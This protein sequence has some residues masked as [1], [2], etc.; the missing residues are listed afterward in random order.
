MSDVRPPAAR[1]LASRKNLAGMA[2]ALVGCGFAFADV[3][4]WPVVAVALYGVG[5]LL[6]PA[7]RPAR[8]QRLTEVLRAELDELVDRSS[9]RRAAALPGGTPAAVERIADVLR[10]VLDRLDDVADRAVDRN[11]APERLA[12]VAAIV[13]SDLPECLEGYLGRGRASSPGRAAAQLVRQLD[14]IAAAV[15]RLAADVPDQH[16]LRAEELTR[17]LLRR[18]G[19]PGPTGG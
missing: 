16:A 8:E 17:D 19:E 18:Y 13:R 15:D 11:A 6:A 10:L 9:H 7:D 2:G 3:G 14:V 5:A 1:W 12:T 4:A